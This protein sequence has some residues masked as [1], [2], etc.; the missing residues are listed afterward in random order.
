MAKILYALMGDARGHFSRSLSVAQH[1]PQHEYLFLGGGAVLEMREMGYHV[2]ELPMLA[3]YYKHGR[4]DVPG[5][6]ANAARILCGRG[7]ILQR[8]AEL[9][10][11]FDPDLILSDYEYFTPLAARRL[12][13]PCYSLDHQHVLTH[14]RYTPPTGQIYPRWLTF[15]PILGLYSNAT[16]F[17]VSSF[18][19]LPPKTPQTEIFPPVLRQLV[20]NYRPF[21]GEHALV[22]MGNGVYE[23]IIPSLTARDRLFYVYGFGQ[24]PA[25]GN[26]VFRPKS[27]GQFMEDLAS[28][29]YVISNGG[30]SLIS[31]AL[32]FGKPILCFPIPNVYEQF[33]N[34]HFLANSGFGLSSVDLK[35]HGQ[36][37]DA[38][39]KG[40]EGFAATIAKHNFWGNDKITARLQELMGTDRDLK[41]AE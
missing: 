7:K 33:L 10:R 27:T 11:A 4:V 28:C 3:T 5:T 40:R 17:L 41:I 36:L 30:H 34:G 13:R 38:M 35:T 19:E 23:D 9:I 14:C 29:S 24:R 21:S 16:R 32:Y 8:L 37:L 2:E 31:E 39:E 25:Q 6:V 12:G 22:Y 20:K 18:Y 26:V 15:V 1:M